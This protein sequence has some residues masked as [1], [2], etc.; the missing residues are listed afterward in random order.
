MKSTSSIIALTLTSALALPVSA[1]TVNATENPFLI[2]MLAN[3]YQVANH[4][5]EKAK[6]GKC[7]EG[8]CGA[9]MQDKE[10]KDKEQTKSDAKTKEGK[11]GEGKC[12]AE[13]KDMTKTDVKAK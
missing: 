10:M 12:G 3:G 9:E 11:C 1:T 4:H 7:G 5:E 8:K 13:M 2:K 6:D